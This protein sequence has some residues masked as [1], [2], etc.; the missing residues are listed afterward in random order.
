VSTDRDE[1]ERTAQLLNDV[2]HHEPPLSADA[3]RWYYDDNPVAP[4]AVGRVEEDGRRIGN[5]ALVPQVYADPAGERRT[6]G[7]GVDLAVDPDARGSGAFRRT[8]E[9]SYERGRA[10]GFDGIL[11]VANA[12]SAPR[13]VATLGWRALADLPVTLC[14]PVGRPGPVEHHAVTPGLLDGPVFERLTHGGF[15]LPRGPGFAPDWTPDSLRWRLARPGASYWLHGTDHHLAVSTRTHM[16]GVPFAVLL[17]VLA[18]PGLTAPIPSGRVAAALA[19]HHR[20]PFVVHWGRNPWL[21]VR[22]VRLPQSRM[23]SPLSLVLHSF[24]D[25]F[26]PATFELSAMEFLDFDAY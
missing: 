6:L 11:G 19:R 1:L 7:V 13:M 25:G 9:D 26:V 16:A 20:T 5:Y 12:N 8:V 10:G 24:H 18:R 23:P 2:F 22:G 4:A 3:L 15:V 17:K 14:P 21:R